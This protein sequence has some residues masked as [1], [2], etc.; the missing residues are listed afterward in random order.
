MVLHNGIVGHAG[1]VVEVVVV[2]GAV[3]VNI[4]SFRENEKEKLI[5]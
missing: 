4:Y 5:V 2:Y 3:V 1:S